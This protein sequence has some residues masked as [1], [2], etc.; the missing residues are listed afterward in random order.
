MR[1]A[2]GEV[3]SV[4]LIQRNFGNYRQTNRKP[5]DWDFGYGFSGCSAEFSVVASEGR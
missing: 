4:E 1:G 2:P 3:E 5:S